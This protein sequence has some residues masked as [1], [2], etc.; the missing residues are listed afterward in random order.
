MITSLDLIGVIG[1][2]E[3]FSKICDEDVVRD[4]KPIVELRPTFG[5]YLTEWWRFKNELLKNYIPRTPTRT[6]DL[7][8]S[9]LLKVVSGRQRKKYS[10]IMTTS[11]P[12]VPR[13]KISMLK[14]HVITDLNSRIFKLEAIIQVLVRKTKGVVVDK[15]EFNLDIDEDADEFRMKLEEDEMLLFK[16]E[17]ILEEESR[18]R[19]EEEAK[20]MHEEEN[21]LEE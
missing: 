13:S 10:R 7:F 18:L 14:D 11:I 20:M 1:D 2:E 5:E 3:F 4:S 12:T 21:M 8:D 19:L 15:L 17:Q 16:E 9:Y 6:L